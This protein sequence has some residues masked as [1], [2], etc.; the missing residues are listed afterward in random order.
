[1]S[2]MLAAKAALAVRV[3]ALADESTLELGVE[4]RAKL[5]A[6]LKHMEE[7]SVSGPMTHAWRLLGD[8]VR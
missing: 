8:F 2:R 7:G 3:D 5:E 1:M 6:R 4:H